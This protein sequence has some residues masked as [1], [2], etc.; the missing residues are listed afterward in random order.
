[1][2]KKKK[3]WLQLGLALPQGSGGSSGAS[4]T[5]AYT[6]ASE[7]SHDTI[8][9]KFYEADD[10]TPKSV[11]V[12]YFVDGA[13]FVV[14]DVAFKI[15][16][17]TPVGAAVA[18]SAFTDYGV[19]AVAGG[20]TYVANGL[21]ESPL[22]P[23]YRPYY[24]G[25]PY[26]GQAFD[27]LLGVSGNSSEAAG[28]MAYDDT[29]QKDPTLKGAISISIGD[30]RGFVKSRRRAGLT[31]S[32]TIPG[33]SWRHFDAFSHLSVV[34]DIPP[35]GAFS[36]CVSL[37][38]GHALRTDYFTVSQIDWSAI[39]GH[40][41]LPVSMPSMA[42]MLTAGV[43]VGGA[44]TGL[45][46]F[47]TECQPFYG[48]FGEYNRRYVISPA[49]DGGLGG[50]GENSGYSRDYG[51]QWTDWLARIIADGPSVNTTALYRSIAFGIQIH[52]L[53]VCGVPGGSGAGQWAGFKQF[54]QLVGHLF[55]AAR[56]DLMD[57]I[58]EIVGNPTG[59]QK[60]I[61][62]DVVG[63]DVLWGTA[64]GSNH[65]VQ[66]G[67]I[68]DEWLDR[69]HF[70]FALN[71]D[72]WDANFD[73]DY[74]CGSA[75]VA[76]FGEYVN[77]AMFQAGPSGWD[78]SRLISQASDISTTAAAYTSDESAINAYWDRYATLSRRDLFASGDS[79][80]PARHLAY[81][82]AVR[83][84]WD[85]PVW[86]GT[87][88]PVTIFGTKQAAS[89]NLTATAT[90]FSWDMSNIY[91][92]TET[93]LEYQVQYSLGQ[94]SWQDVTTQGVSGTQTGLAPG[95][96]HYVRWRRRSASGWGPWSICYKRQ[97]TDTN[98]QMYI[99]PTNP[100]SGTTT[101]TVAPS[102]FKRT[103][104]YWPGPIYEPLS[105]TLDINITQLV[106]GV[107]YWT[108]TL[109]GGPSYQ[110]KRDGA[111]ISGATSQTYTRVKADFGH[112]V[113]CT[114]TFNGTSATSNAVT[115]PAVTD[116]EFVIARMGTA[117]P[118][119]L[120][121]IMENM[122]EGMKADATGDLWALVQSFWANSLHNATDSLLN[123]KDD[124][125]TLSYGGGMSA[126]EFVA[127]RGFTPSISGQYLE[128]GMPDNIGGNW[129]QDQ[130]CLFAYVAVDGGGTNSVV[131]LSAGSSTFLTPHISGTRRG[132]IHASGNASVANG[133]SSR[134]GWTIAVRETSTDLVVYKDTTASAV[135]A[136][137]S[138][139][140][141]T[142][143]FRLYSAGATYSL[144]RAPIWGTAKWTK[145]QAMAAKVH[146]DTFLT[147]LLAM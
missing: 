43:E 22:M 59:Q 57:E 61:T 71:E 131:G 77:I 46:Y 30:A 118:A 41:L 67:I 125:Y 135:V 100:A 83:S 49:L 24:P 11:K 86:Q 23:A 112:D 80:T 53:A 97:D 9:W 142:A 85:M 54:A 7:I 33:G 144:D 111:N 103:Y 15:A 128:S 105:G 58:L 68:T 40:A 110:W 74:E 87:P 92:N 34:P 35:A 66:R 98:E 107:G 19:G 91:G 137:A 126:S 8:T 88:D 28:K 104:S 64:E 26:T 94:V 12:G 141:T 21:M 124:P 81:Y 134:L 39:P 146:M 93:I 78:G 123:W 122:I 17:V 76:S 109:T 31:T 136:T 55:H 13:P 145:A 5:L 16:Q 147:A 18:S 38:A 25:V 14:S 1:M 82:D 117:A 132:R 6:N 127:Y 44:G 139:A 116:T 45:G 69:P 99:T 95:Y 96:K 115:L 113:T 62:N 75:G 50:M 29:L 140:P 51:Q 90:G 101:N 32:G 47:H 130:A 106:C 73:A 4:T 138:N 3:R 2:A 52:G 27:G 63:L 37:P 121:T 79:V 120:E 10:V 143:T 108:G 60:W 119:P 129:L 102:L 20:T 70:S 56:P 72:R 89:G 84:G 42:T 48:Q 36:P 65:G 114:V 133:G